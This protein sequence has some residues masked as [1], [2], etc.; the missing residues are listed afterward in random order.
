MNRITAK[1]EELKQQNQKAFIGFLTAG[2]PDVDTCLKLLKELDKNGCD[3]I[4]IGVPFSDPIAE[5]VVIQ[6]ANIRALSKGINTKKVMQ[7]VADF[8]KETDK[9]LLFLLYYNQVFK[10]GTEK[11]LQEAKASG[12]DGLI[13]PDLPYEHHG[14]IKPIA[15]NYD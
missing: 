11:F 12:I 1:F 13:I 3:V 5:G 6:N 15:K 7:L 14:E 9:P 2:D 8:R 10:Y 4:E